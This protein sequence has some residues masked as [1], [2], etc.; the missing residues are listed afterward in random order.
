MKTEDRT[1][2]KQ[3]F[4]IANERD[5]GQY[6]VDKKILSKTELNKLCKLMPKFQLIIIYDASINGIRYKTRER[7][8][9]VMNRV[10]ET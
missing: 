2:T 5:D 4:I 1:Q 8:L 9:G 10:F 7:A 6:E 3:M